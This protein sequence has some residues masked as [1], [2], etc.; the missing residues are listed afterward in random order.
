MLLVV[1]GKNYV[2]K[3]NNSHALPSSIGKDLEIRYMNLEKDSH[4]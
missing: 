4:I 1:S 2:E 3:K